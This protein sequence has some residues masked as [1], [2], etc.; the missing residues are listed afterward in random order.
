MGASAPPF[1]RKRKG[2]QMPPTHNLSAAAEGG[3]SSEQTKPLVG[4][5]SVSSS[6]TSPTPPPPE[7][8]LVRPVIFR[9]TCRGALYLDDDRT[10]TMGAAKSSLSAADRSRQFDGAM[11]AP[12][13]PT[14]RCL[15]F[16]SRLRKIRELPPTTRRDDAVRDFV[17]GTAVED[18]GRTKK[19]G[20][21]SS[22]ATTSGRIGGTTIDATAPGVGVDSPPLGPP[23]ALPVGP[24]AADY[25]EPEEDDGG[26]NGNPKRRLSGG[27]KV[28]NSEEEADIQDDSWSN[29]ACYGTTQVSVLMLRDAKKAEVVA[30]AP[31]NTLGVT[32]RDVGDATGGEATTTLRIGPV[33]VTV[34]NHYEFEDETEEDAAARSEAETGSRGTADGRRREEDDEVRP[35]AWPPGLTEDRRGRGGRKEAAAPERP[36][37]DPNNDPG[38]MR[39]TRGHHDG[40]ARPRIPRDRD[41]NA[42]AN[43]EEDFSERFLRT[44]QR[45]AHAMKDNAKMVTD[46]LSDDKFPSRVAQSG[47]RIAGQFGKT[48]ERTKKVAVDVYR[49]WTSDDDDDDDDHHD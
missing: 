35:T 26:G 40:K 21:S 3:P 17:D 20:A 32:V 19:E 8:P 36:A 18:V 42:S 16:E 30:V 41:G 22:R 43:D 11:L 14:P 13:L 6:E 5:K 44:L 37:W 25:G 7:P 29:M 27:V 31:E 34:G 1:L 33:E 46:E 39:P 49:M 2:L 28:G 9:Y 24:G 38:G 23:K 47:G 12:S 48:L 4:E 45:T 10:S 15:G